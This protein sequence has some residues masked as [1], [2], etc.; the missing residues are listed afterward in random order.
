ML[1]DFY[2]SSKCN[3]DTHFFLG[4][5][6]KTMME[7][8]SHP[9][10]AWHWWRDPHDIHYNFNSRGYRDSEWPTD[11]GSDLI[12]CLGD[13]LTLGVGVPV[14]H[15]WPR[16]LQDISRTRC[17]NISMAGA[18][19][20]WIYRKAR[21]LIH[22]VRPRRMMLLWTWLHRREYSLHEVYELRW[23][24]F[25]QALRDPSW[26]LQVSWQQAHELPI[27]ILQELKSSEFWPNI[28]LRDLDEARLRFDNQPHDYH[29]VAH[30]TELVQDLESIRGKTCLVHAWL[31]Q[32]G[33]KAQDL[34]E[35]NIKNCTG[36]P[37]YQVN[38]RDRSR[39]YIHFGINTND[40]VSR[41][42]S[43]ASYLG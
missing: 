4:D 20:Q 39:D 37:F 17:V 2:C 16:R 15:S 18:S 36:Q 28:D 42:F 11:L 21:E 35:Q 13:S 1:D 14:E 23:Q 26:P 8:V 3:L 38:W 34:L 5:R 25:Y 31:P 24:E 27:A 33:G 29:D 32:V 40:S 19:N 10:A 9:L 30:V 41:L 43:E 6:P 12:W 22:Y 7:V